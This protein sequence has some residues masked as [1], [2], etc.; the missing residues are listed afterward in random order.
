MTRIKS[1][2]FVFV[3]LTCSA[4]SAFAIAKY[5][6]GSGNWSSTGIW[7]LTDGGVTGAPV[8]STTDTVFLTVNSGNVTADA[9][10]LNCYR[11]SVSSGYTST[12]AFTV[13]VAIGAGGVTL[14][15]NM[16]FTASTTH[17]LS[18][19]TGNQTWTSNGVTVPV[20]ITLGGTIVTLGDNWTTTGGVVTGSGT[21]NSNTLNINGGAFSGSGTITGTTTINFGPTGSPT[22]ST[23]G[24]VSNNITINTTGTLTLGNGVTISFGS[25]SSPTITYTAGTVT[26]T[27]NTILFSAN[28]T[29]N[30][31]GMSFNNVNMSASSATVYTINSLL[32][33]AGTLNSPNFTGAT[34]AGTAGWTCAILN[35]PCPSKT[36]TLHSGNTYT[37]TSQIISTGYGSNFELFN[38][39]TAS[40]SAYLYFTGDTQTILFTNF[41]D[42]SATNGGTGGNTLWTLSNPGATLTRQANIVAPTNYIPLPC[43]GGN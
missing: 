8:P 16:L 15:A 21:L 42:I 32:S 36:I 40:S 33:I 14:G 1:L 9:G 29:L 18:A 13:N 34:F 31:N 17:G 2:I 6:V 10:V 11:L 19:N 37:V 38:A 41:T 4:N 35:F 5:E 25:A 30:T 12:M 27:N 22:W 43:G 39:S 3:L 20:L 28:A 26:N 23:T 7:S 24:A